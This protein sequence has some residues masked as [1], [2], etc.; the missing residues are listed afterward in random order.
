MRILA[1]VPGSVLWLLAAN[2]AATA[3]LRTAARARGV[4]P[5]RLVFAPNL[6][7]ERHLARLR[8]ADLF[9]DS[10][11]YNAHTTASDA[12]WAGVPV[13]TKRGE[14]FAGRVAES[15]LRAVGLPELVAPDLA[16]F[17]AEAIAL[18]S[19]PLRLRSLREK[20]AHNRGTAPLFDS[21]RFTRDLE[22]AYQAMWDIHRRGEA[23][24]S[25]AVA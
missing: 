3:N 9:L 8:L 14:T 23:P 18:A 12:L 7:L 4:A 22:A 25:F 20:L 2:P 6:P 15:L 1:A 19:E 10:F 17:E 24:H 5:Q 21:P 16:A 11:P 13:L